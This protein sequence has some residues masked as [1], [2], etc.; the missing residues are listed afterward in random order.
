M[1]WFG[2]AR[3]QE[4]TDRNGQSLHLSPWV[5]AK[6]TAMQSLLD[7]RRGKVSVWQADVFGWLLL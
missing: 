4:I 1:L 5:R 3:S 2:T 6:T 7:G